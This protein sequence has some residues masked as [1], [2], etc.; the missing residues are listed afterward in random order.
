MYIPP[1]DQTVCCGTCKPLG[2]SYNGTIYS[3]GEAIPSDKPCRQKVCKVTPS[4]QPTIIEDDV[5][6]P[7]PK[8]YCNKVSISYM[9]MYM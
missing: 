2:C 1:S 8:R 5:T 4:G 9:Y 7:Q 6:C 3:D